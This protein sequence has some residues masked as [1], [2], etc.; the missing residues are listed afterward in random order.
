MEITVQEL[1]ERLS[2]NNIPLFLDIREEWE[3]EEFNIGAK[4]FPFYSMPQR[5]DE[6]TDYKTQEIIIH[7]KT[8]NRGDKAIKFLKQ[9]GFV[10]VKNLEGGIQSFKEYSAV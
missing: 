5:L 9:H 7:C 3:Y 1:K 10:N 8:G 6:L 2:N 4:N